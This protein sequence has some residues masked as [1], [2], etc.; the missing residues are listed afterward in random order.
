MSASFLLSI[1]GPSHS[2]Y[3]STEIPSTAQLGTSATEPRMSYVQ[4][5]GAL[6]ITRRQFRRDS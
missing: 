5:G 6:Y 3:L 1:K 4:A 2:P